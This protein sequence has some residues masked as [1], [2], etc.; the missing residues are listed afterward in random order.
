MQQPASAR[1]KTRSRRRPAPAHD[2]RALEAERAADHRALRLAGI[3]PDAEPPADIDVFRVALARRIAIY[4]GT[5][6]K[7]W[8]TCKE[9]RC[10]RVRSCLAPHN[11]C[12][13]APPLPADPDGKEWDRVR[14]EVQRALKAR[15]A[16]AGAADD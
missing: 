9:R 13:K 2:Q 15:L 16:A 11:R 1:R 5:R 10:R 6:N 14:V 3:D 4:V 8:R 12:S 7:S